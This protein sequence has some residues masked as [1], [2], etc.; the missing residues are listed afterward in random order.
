MNDQTRMTEAT[1]EQVVEAYLLRREEARDQTPA[2]AGATRNVLAE[3]MRLY[4][5]YADQL[6]EYVATACIVEYVPAIEGKTT[7]ER[8]EEDAIIKRG[9]E[10]ASRL[11]AARRNEPTLTSLRKTAET[12]GLTMQTLAAQTNL[13]VPLLMKLDRRLIRF[14][15][16]PRVVVERIGAAINET[17]EAVTAYLQGERKFAIGAAFL[18]EEAPQMPDQQDFFEAIEKDLTMNATQKQ[19]WRKIREKE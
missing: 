16:I 11:L 13:S 12:R 5:Q 7:E 19:E 9:M 6:M 4:P 8:V 15:S 18:A 10:T 17:S 2:G 14:A 1:F 3:F